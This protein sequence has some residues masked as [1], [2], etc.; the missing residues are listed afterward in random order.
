M[1]WALIAMLVFGVLL[2]AFFSGSE[3]GFYRV[4]RMRL[5][6]D[7]LGGDSI[8]RG[9]LWLT[10][11]PSLFVATT[12]IGNNVANYMTSLAIVL[13][14]VA[15]Y[16]DDTYAAEIIAPVLFSPLVFAY[17]ELLPK[18]LFF[19]AP[20]KLLR[21][22][23]PLFL[24]F[25]VIFAPISAILWTLGRGLQWLIGEA[26]THVRL[27]VARKELQRA[28][29]QGQE[30]GI[31]MPFQRELAQSLL[32]TAGKSVMD[33]ATRPERVATVRLGSKK[34]D[35][36]RLARRHRTAAVPVTEETGRELAGY[37]R[38]VD[39]YLDDSDRVENVR[40]L[41]TITELE[42]HSAALIHMQSEKETLAKVVDE[43]GNTVGLLSARRL[44]EPLFRGT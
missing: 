26:P 22:G 4:A 32:V 27:T 3:T 36:L 43:Q 34:S 35:V 6:M 33:F 7:A 29:Q 38:I 17:G 24:F 5:V 13:L 25:T 20:N 41:M 42:T 19:H 28:F 44:T 11:N 18:N 16:G 8:A 39:L 21:L 1:I 37:V 30:E 40:P 9:L 12:L 14:T 23:G 15:Y 10:N 31:L 2:S